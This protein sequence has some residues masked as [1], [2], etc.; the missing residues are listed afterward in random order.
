[1]V[2]RRYMA[3]LSQLRQASVILYATDFTNREKLQAPIEVTIEEG[4][5]DGFRE[6][7]VDLPE[8]PLDLIIHSPGGSPFVTE[9][10]VKFLRQKFD[11]ITAFVPSSAKSAAAMLALSADEIFMDAMAELGPIDPQ[12]RVPKEGQI[13]QSPAQAIIDQFEWARDEVGQHPERMGGLLPTLRFVAPSLLMEARNAIDLSREIVESWLKTYMFRHDRRKSSKA[14]RIAAYLA[15]HNNFK[16]H[17]RRVDIGL[18]QELG[19]RVNDITSDPALYAAVGRV[20][21]ST[22]HT[23]SMTG[24]YKLIENNREQAYVKMLRRE[25]VALG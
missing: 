8:G 10:I 6:V 24:A 17:A 25:L 11:P 7:S 15:D 12:L 9:T 19:V 13:I 3:E 23:F 16:A 22:V 14:K 20:Y 2:R 18:L 4:D 5:K 21:Y 1:M